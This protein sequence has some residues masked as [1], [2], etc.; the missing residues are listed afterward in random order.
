MRKRRIKVHKTGGVVARGVW[1]VTCPEHGR[2][3]W[4]YYWRSSYSRAVQHS[5]TYHPV[6]EAL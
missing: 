6:E 1:R 3:G 5:Q 2:V 4:S